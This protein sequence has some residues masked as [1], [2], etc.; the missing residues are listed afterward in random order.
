MIKNQSI[1]V[2]SDQ[3]IPFA[4]PDLFIFLKAIKK[5]YKPDRVINLGDE[6]DYHA[7]SFHDSDPDLLSPSDELKKGIAGLKIMMELFPKMDLMESNHGSLVYRK[8]KAMGL[9]RHVF[10]SYQDIV[11][12]PRGW[13]WHSHLV[14]KMSNGAN[15]YFCHSK[16]SDVL[17]VSQAMGM[18]VVQGHSHS[19]FEIRY[20]GNS[21]GLYWAM[22]SG[23]LIDDDSLAYSY[24][25]L[26]LKRPV[27]GTSVII[28]GIPKLIPMILDKNRRWIG[29][30]P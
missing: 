15:C 6:L 10:K 28:N 11:G 20:W 12:A 17:K 29:V 26:T 30:L 24:N 18:S 19:Q 22:T 1:L 21:L 13:R 3:H 8:G 14:V 16:G 4:H 23:C 2:I 5:K 25:K 9:P 27:I 7:I